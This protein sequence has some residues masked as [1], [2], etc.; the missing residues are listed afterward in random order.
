VPNFSTVDG[1]IGSFGPEEQEVLQK[2]RVL[3]KVEVPEAEEA[4]KYGIPTFVYHGNMISFAAFDNHY[5]I[6]PA[7]HLVEAKVPELLH[8]LKGAATLQFYKDISMPYPLIRRMVAV[9]AKEMIEKG[10]KK[11]AQKKRVK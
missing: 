8:Y 11:L 10:E 1:Y 7:S 2:L 9:R 6:F 4:I 5:S 3:I